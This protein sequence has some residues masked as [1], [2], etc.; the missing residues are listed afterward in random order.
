MRQLIDKFDRVLNES[1]LNRLHYHVMNH[2]CAIISAFRNKLIN[3]IDGEY[4]DVK[5]GMKDNKSRNRDLKSVLLTLNYGVTDV[6][7]TYIENY[8]SDNQVEVVEDS[9]FVVNLHD[10]PN[11]VK[12]IIRLGE[13]FC[14]DSV[15]IIEKGGNDSYLVGTN[16]FINPGFGQKKSI[17]RFKPGIESEFMTKVGGR[18][19]VIECFR[20]LQINSK[21]LVKEFAKPILE[22]L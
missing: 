15:C 18:P 10:E 1:N 8:L 16:N 22:L 19:F 4:S 12:N 5:L 7:G 20:D 6:I 21:R 9:F 17:G 2:D 11:F 14:Q 13:I 3:C